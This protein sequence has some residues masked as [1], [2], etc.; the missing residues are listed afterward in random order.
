ML[1]TFPEFADYVW[2]FYSP[3]SALYPIKG[4]TIE[5]VFQESILIS[6]DY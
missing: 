4:L 3:D 5:D 1:E 2:D 6:R